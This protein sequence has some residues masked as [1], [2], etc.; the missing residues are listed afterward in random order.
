[1]TITFT[2]PGLDPWVAHTPTGHWLTGSGLPCGTGVIGTGAMSFEELSG[3]APRM[4]ADPTAD[5]GDLLPPGLREQLT[6][7]EL[8]GPGGPETESALPAGTTGEIPTTHFLHDHPALLDRRPL[9]PSLRTLVRFAEATD[10]LAGLRGQFAS[11]ARRHGPEA[12]AEASRLLLSAFRDGEE[13]AP[14]PF[15]AMAALLRPLSLIAGRDGGSGLALDLP[16]RLLDQAFGSRPVVRFEDVDLPEALTH[17]PTRRFLR[18]VGLPEEAHVFSL[19]TDVPLATPA[20]YHADCA[21]PACPPA[22]AGRLIRL[23]HLADGHSLLVDGETGAVLHWDEAQSA[24]RPLNTDVSTLAFT[25]WL[26]HRER[27]P[28]G[29]SRPEP[30]T[31]VQD[32][33]A[34]T[35]LQVL[36]TVDRANGTAARTDGHHGS[37]ASQ[38]GAGGVL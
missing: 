5:L 18:E 12:V 31:G 3:D 36:A 6:T 11:C 32:Q 25:L 29:G 20:E 8:P 30:S 17:E 27:T 24:L 19:D 4:V 1:M 33:L 9:A 28:D 13:G 26:L 7:G 15:R 14:A 16:H 21:A 37:G 35:M 22:G 38:G 10:E 23:G 2:G 34:M